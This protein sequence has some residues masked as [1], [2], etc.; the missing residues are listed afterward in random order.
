MR[1]GSRRRPHHQGRSSVKLR[2]ARTEYG[3]YTASRTARLSVV[4]VLVDG[5]IG[6]LAGVKFPERCDGPPC[7]PSAS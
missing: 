5:S 3:N 2:L 1:T 6:T 7:K 4:S